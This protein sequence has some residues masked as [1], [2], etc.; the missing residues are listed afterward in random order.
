[1]DPQIVE[2][3][4]SIKTNKQINSFDEVSTK[5]AIVLRLLFLLGW[6]IFNID[7]VTPNLP[8][9]TQFVD[10]A[11]RIKNTDTVF[12]KVVKPKEALET[13]QDKVFEYGAEKAVDVTILTNGVGWWF[14]LSSSKGDS[15]LNRFCSLDFV[16]Q[17]TDEVV[18][19]LIDFL[20]KDEIVKGKSLKNALKIL[21]K[22]QQLA[23]R[24]AIPEAW[25]RILSEP[26]EALIKLIGETAEKMCGVTAEKDAIV[27]FLTDRA[28]KTH[29]TAAPI[30]Y[31]EEKPPAQTEKPAPKSYNGQ[32]ITSFSMKGKK[33]RVNSWNELLVK[34]CEALKTEY[35]QD[36]ESLQWLSVGRKYYFTKNQKELRVPKHIGKTDIFVESYLNPNE[37]VKVALAVLTEFGFST[38]DFSVS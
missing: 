20:K 31:R 11:L 13:Y 16:E 34:M 32:A 27:E 10:Y 22:K 23:A 19:Q 2:F 18:G 38:D 17:K 35:E 12:I 15:L 21:K 37:T 9:E 8:D 1:M 3:V 28:K 29:P 6:D 24:D 7:E 4:N 30:P 25:S 5:Q 36:I 33:Y 14:F 26:H